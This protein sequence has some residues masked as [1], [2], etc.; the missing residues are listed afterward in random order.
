MEITK[1][2]DSDTTTYTLWVDGT[3]VSELMLWTGTREV[4]NIETATAYQGQGFA[5]ALWEHASA[6]AECFHSLPHHRTHEGD[7]FARAVGGETI[8]EEDG[9]QDVCS[10]CTDQ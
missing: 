3:E 5:R 9:F 6:E 4:A 1:S 7:A 10:I 2:I 8:S